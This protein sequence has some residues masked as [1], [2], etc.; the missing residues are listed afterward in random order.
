LRLD[1]IGQP[2]D[3]ILSTGAI[4]RHSGRGTVVETCQIA[5]TD[6]LCVQPRR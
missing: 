1:S 2:I 3:H 6:G 5:D 4:D